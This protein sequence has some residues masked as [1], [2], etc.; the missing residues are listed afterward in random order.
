M[1]CSESHATPASFQGAGVVVFCPAHRPAMHG[2]GPRGG[3]AG[4][5][6]SARVSSGV[7][8]FRPLLASP[9]APPPPPNPT[10]KSKKGA[11]SMLQPARPSRPPARILGAFL[12]CV[13]I[14]GLGAMTSSADAQSRRG[15]DRPDRK[16]T[17]TI[18]VQVDLGASAHRGHDRRRGH[19]RSHDRP[20]HRPHVQHPHRPDHRP[21]VQP[22]H[23]P[24][25]RPHV[26]HPHR[27]IIRPNVCPPPR[28]IVR[29]HYPIV[30]PTYHR[31]LPR[32][33]FHH[34]E[35]ERGRIEGRADGLRCGFEAGYHGV[36]YCLDIG[37]IRDC[38]SNAF[39][40][41]YNDAYIRAYR[42]GFRRGQEA[43]YLAQ[44]R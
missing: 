14:G 31:P 19:D 5:S 37:R 44:C 34:L 7:S 39:R 29:P 11:H 20:R 41:G 27:P 3:K 6:V 16:E 36:S 15:R 23:R 17:P 43:L 28:P 9:A 21:H 10:L 18:K 8:D 30:G 40:D 38:E 26:H 32:P 22:P 2:S 25:H 12:A 13:L 33:S 4:I 42:E 24:I 1:I 35:F